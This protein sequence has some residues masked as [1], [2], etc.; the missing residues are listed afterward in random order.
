MGRQL[1]AAKLLN[2]ADIRN[3]ENEHNNG[4]ANNS[5]KYVTD[6]QCRSSPTHDCMCMTLLPEAPQE[7][8]RRQE[9]ANVAGLEY[10]YL[11]GGEG[12]AGTGGGGQGFTDLNRAVD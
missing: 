5:R 9:G 4:L 11:A 1:C 8:T 12:W 10:C 6:S 3:G 7:K 2:G